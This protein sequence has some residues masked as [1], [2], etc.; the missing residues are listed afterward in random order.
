MAKRKIY[1]PDNERDWKRMCEAVRKVER[2][3][4]RP[5]RGPPVR[6]G[7]GGGT[8]STDLHSVAIL[9][10]EEIDAATCVLEGGQLVV[11]GAM[12]LGH[13]WEQ[14]ID[15]GESASTITRTELDEDPVL[16][17]NFSNMGYLEGVLVHTIEGDGELIFEGES[18]AWREI[19]TGDCAPY[20]PDPEV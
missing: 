11:T 13:R 5:K 17:V 16:L 20:D 4:P 7:V 9:T 2:A 14:D 1:G 15:T 10:T 6:R 12:G 19:I 18:R 8:T 3:E